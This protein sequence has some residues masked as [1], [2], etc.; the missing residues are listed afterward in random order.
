MCVTSSIVS[1]P[2]QAF[3]H[4]YDEEVKKA[5]RM[6]EAGSYVGG[7]LTDDMDDDVDEIFHVHKA[8]MNIS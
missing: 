8:I 1:I 5:Q 4:Q 7:A 3:Q 6:S 2:M